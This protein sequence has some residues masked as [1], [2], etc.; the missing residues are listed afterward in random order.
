[1]YWQTC[2]TFRYLLL[3]SRIQKDVEQLQSFDVLKTV[4]KV[5]KG[6]DKLTDFQGT[7]INSPQPIPAKQ[8]QN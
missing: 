2:S 8:I 4:E 3:L 1:M 7:K 6:L 5:T